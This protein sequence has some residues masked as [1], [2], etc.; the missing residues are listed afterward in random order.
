L[1]E[2]TAEDDGEIADEEC[3]EDEQGEAWLNSYEP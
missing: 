2:A 3:V 1:Q